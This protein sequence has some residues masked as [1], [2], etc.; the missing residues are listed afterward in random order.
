MQTGRAPPPPPPNERRRRPTAGGRRGRLEYQTAGESAGSGR[1]RR[2]RR[3]QVVIDRRRPSSGRQSVDDDGGG[4]GAGT[5]R[6]GAGRR[7]GRTNDINTDT[8]R[9]TARRP[10]PFSLSLDTLCEIHLPP[11]TR[12]TADRSHSVS[13]RCRDRRRRGAG[14]CDVFRPDRDDSTPT[15]PTLA[16][17]LLTTIKLIGVGQQC[18]LTP[19]YITGQK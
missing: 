16:A 7:P 13:R 6:A 12:R 9:I 14:Y 1:C 15:R 3:G 5:K 4:G 19:V 18:V 2:G 17:L 8:H 10:L 11:T